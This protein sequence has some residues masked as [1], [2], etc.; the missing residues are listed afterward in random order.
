ME[1]VVKAAYAPVNTAQQVM[2]H[3]FDLSSAE[4]MESAEIQLK[5]NGVPL[6]IFVTLAGPE[7]GKRKQ[8][9]LAK[10][11]RARRELAKTGK[12]QFND[13]IEDEAEQ[14]DLL[15]DCTLS[16]RT[17]YKGADNK[18]QSVPFVLFDGKQY[19]ASR[20]SVLALLDD[21]KRAWFRRAMQE[22]FDDGEA[23]IKVSA[24]V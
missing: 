11:R 3:I 7:H 18:V 9:A 13:P 21:P 20:D 17:E 4:D 1:E 10:Q 12:L 16:W 2:A 8:F 19:D 22:A 24:S 14:K 5:R 6:P 23:F 15:A